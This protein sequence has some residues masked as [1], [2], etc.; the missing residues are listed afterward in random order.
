MYASISFWKRPRMPEWASIA[1]QRTSCAFDAG[2][3]G[4]DRHDLT[5]VGTAEDGQVE[6]DRVPSGRRVD[7]HSVVAAVLEHLDQIRRTAS[8]QAEMLALARPAR[9]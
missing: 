1:S 7:H 9:S 5:F 3:C 8:N 2:H 6:R 4:S